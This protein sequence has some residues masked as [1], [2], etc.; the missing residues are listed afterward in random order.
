MKK[1]QHVF[2]I[3]KKDLKIVPYRGSGAGGQK[4]NKT[5]SGCR[6]IHEPSGAIGE[7]E[8]QRDY[9]QNEK[10]AFRRMTETLNFKTWMK[11]QED[12]ILGRIKYEEMDDK[13]NFVERTLTPGE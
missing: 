9:K 4:R 3:T 6:V 10:V 8:E 2:S 12:I 11:L 7:S 1:R 13:G 5:M